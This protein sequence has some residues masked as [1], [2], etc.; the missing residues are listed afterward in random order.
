MKWVL[1]ESCYKK[2][3]MICTSIIPFMVLIPCLSL[4]S[5]SFS[6]IFFQFFYDPLPTPT[7]KAGGSVILCHSP[8]FVQQSSSPHASTGVEC[9]LLG[10]AA[11]SKTESRG[12]VSAGTWSR[13][14]MG[15]QYQSI[16]FQA[17]RFRKWTTYLWLWEFSVIIMKAN[18]FWLIYARH[19]A[20][21][22]MCILVF[23]NNPL[24]LTFHI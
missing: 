2:K 3:H 5:Q 15:Q 4:S 17:W 22:L 12:P 7:P 1:G 10:P 8:L 18:R 13:D 20:R 24:R 16:D 11:E 6:W 14:P 9:S 19:C 21:H 23:L